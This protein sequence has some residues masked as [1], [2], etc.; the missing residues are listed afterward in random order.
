MA[1]YEAD[2]NDERGPAHRPTQGR[3]VRRPRRVVGVAAATIG[4]VPAFAGSGDPDLPKIT[5]QQLIEKIA[6]S[7]VQQLSGTV[8]ITTDLGL[9]E[10]RRPG[11]QPRR[12]N[13]P[14]RRRLGFLRG[15]VVQAA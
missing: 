14:G 11:E 2:D 3:A 13:G 10:S 7:D 8:K 5:A 6:A 15:P 4:L 12:R 9:P 1:P